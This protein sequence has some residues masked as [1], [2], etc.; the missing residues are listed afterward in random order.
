MVTVMIVVVGYH[1]LPECLMAII[2]KANS[3]KELR[4]RTPAKLYSCETILQRLAHNLEHMTAKLGQFIQKAH[5]M[6]SQRHVARHRH[7]APTDQP[8]SEMVWWGARHGRVVTHAVRAPVRPATLWIRVVSM[9]SARVMQASAR[10]W[11][12]GPS[13]R[14]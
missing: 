5:A 10:S 6:V 8:A 14:Q 13:R 7:V 12:S 4:S 9:A 11:A 1:A 3:A 2:R